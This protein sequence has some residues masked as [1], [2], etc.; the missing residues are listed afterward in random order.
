MRIASIVLY[1]AIYA[2][3]MTPITM[4]GNG[5]PSNP[6]TYPYGGILNSS[7][8]VSNNMD[9]PLMFEEKAK[10]EFATFPQRGVRFNHAVFR[11]IAWFN[12]AVFKGSADFLA[13]TFEGHTQFD[14]SR[15]EYTASFASSEFWDGASFEESTFDTRAS[16]VNTRFD[17]YVR[18]VGVKFFGPVDFNNAKFNGKTNFSNARFDTTA[19]FTDAVFSD[20]LVLGSE[21]SHKFNFRRT[22]FM[23]GAVLLLNNLVE[24]DI[25]E[26]K[27]EHICLKETLSYFAKK[28]IIE[29]LKRK[30]FKEDAGAQHE[31]SYLLARSTM[32]QNQSHTYT[33]N[34]ACEFWKWPQWGL[35]AIYYRT[36]GLGYE[37]FL[38]FYWVVGLIPFW[39]LYYQWKMT[40]A[41]NTYVFKGMANW[42]E[43][44]K[45]DSFLNALY[46]SSMVFF[47]LTFKRRVLSHFSTRQKTAVGF[48]WLLG[49]FALIAFLTQ[50]QP[51]AI[52]N[53][54][55][56]LFGRF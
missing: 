7:G 40:N 1:M 4:A 39:A 54:V 38:L 32:Y 27:F 11:D 46:F 8:F 13:V 2:I 15:F 12:D 25:Q 16:F 6:T 30:S 36:M 35:T 41:V 51:A 26:E 53:S 37:P 55:R 56:N 14:L 48:Q 34:T 10:F 3:L 33:R 50:S 24:L 19:S 18:F 29:H 9:P 44:S 17:G 22:T 49:T 31:L 45:V 28:D 42:P 23:P 5:L 21:K 20:T 47:P 52:W 43:P